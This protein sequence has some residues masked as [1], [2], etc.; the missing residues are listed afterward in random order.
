VRWSSGF[1]GSTWIAARAALRMDY[2]QD[3]IEMEACA[4]YACVLRLFSAPIAGAISS[5]C[6][7]ASGAITVYQGATLIDGIEKIPRKSMSIVVRG[8]RIETIAPASELFLRQAAKWWMLQG[9]MCCLGS[10]TRTFILRPTQPAKRRSG[11]CAGPLQR[12]DG[13]ADMAGDH[14]AAR[15]SLPVYLLG[16]VAGPDIYYAAL[17]AGPSFFKDERTHDAARGPWPEK[18]RG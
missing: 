2:E 8:E 10:S 4:R 12:R 13:R 7:C 9:S 17:M 18:C 16:E 6:V 3:H 11:L 15:G 5:E 14:T 1:E